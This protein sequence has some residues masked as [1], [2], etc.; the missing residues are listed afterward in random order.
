MPLSLGSITH[1]NNNNNNKNSN[2]PIYKVPKA[3]ASEALVAGQSWVL[4]KSLTDEV[5]LEPRFKAITGGVYTSLLQ[6]LG[7]VVKTCVT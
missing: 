3:L 5:R 6:V 7:M 4:I 1:N 2:N